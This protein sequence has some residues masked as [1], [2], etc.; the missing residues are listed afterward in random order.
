[1]KFLAL[2]ITAALSIAPAFADDSSPVG[3]WKNIDDVSGKPKALI[4]I[5]DTNGVLQ[6][7]IEQLFR[8]PSE[9][10]NPKCEKCEDA[11]KNQPVI[12]LVIMTGLKKDGDE[13]NGGEILDPD[14]GKVYR[15]KMH[16]TDGGKKLSVRGYIGVPMLGRS[17]VWVR[18]E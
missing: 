15:S 12:G 13:Y 7:K 5:T 2:L 10:Q 1:M 3:L 6:G 9:D 4:R 8:A 17:Q 14:N 11:R 16:L 18:Q